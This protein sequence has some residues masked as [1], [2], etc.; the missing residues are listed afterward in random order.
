MCVWCSNQDGCEGSRRGK[1]GGVGALLEEEP[2]AE[3]LC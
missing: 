2:P 3:E 1:E